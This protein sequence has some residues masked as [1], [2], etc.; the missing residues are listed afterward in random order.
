MKYKLNFY[1]L[2]E[3]ITNNFFLSKYYLNKN[4]YYKYLVRAE[5]KLKYLI[6]NSFNLNKT[7]KLPS[8]SKNKTEIIGYS[9]NVE[10][11]FFSDHDF[12]LYFILP[13]EQFYQRYRVKSLSKMEIF[14][15][16]IKRL[17]KLKKKKKLKYAIIVKAIKAG[18]V[19][20]T[21][22]V[23]GFMPCQSYK[24]F[25]FRFRERFFLQRLLFQSK[26]KHYSFFW[27]KLVI[28]N[29]TILY[30]YNRKKFNPNPN[31]RLYRSFSVLFLTERRKKIIRRYNKYLKRSENK[32]MSAKKRYSYV[33]NKKN[34]FIF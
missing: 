7:I 25:I 3:H 15:S 34:S 33:K 28:A 9:I 19:V 22:G 32:K 20:Y 12:K 2:H 17:F 31:F 26:V 23:P 11:Y 6:D 24:E 18:Y 10:N 13:H 14:A 21:T 1:N 8:I 27:C 5:I 30:C 16:T 4:I 29:I